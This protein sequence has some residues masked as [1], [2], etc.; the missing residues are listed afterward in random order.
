MSVTFDV[1]DQR[2]SIVSTLTIDDNS[3]TEFGKIYDN[4]YFQGL[5]QTFGG[6]HIERRNDNIP[7]VIFKQRF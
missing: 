3:L 6:V 1:K 2:G 5:E 7:K 4:S